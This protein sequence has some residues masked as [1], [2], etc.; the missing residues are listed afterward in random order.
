MN[1]WKMNLIEEST[2]LQKETA[3]GQTNYLNGLACVILRSL[4]RYI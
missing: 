3:E 4:I 2:V 1:E